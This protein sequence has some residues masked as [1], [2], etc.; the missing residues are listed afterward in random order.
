LEK[1]LLG[2][3]VKSHGYRVVAKGLNAAGTAEVMRE[4]WDKYRHCVAV[5]LDASRF[6]QHVGQDAL[7]F[8]HSCYTSIFPASHELPE[9]LRM[10]LS[11]RGQGFAEGKK[12]KYR[13]EGCRMSGDINT[14]MGNC[15]I[16]SSIVLGYLRTRGIDARLTNNG[17]DCVL[18]LEKHDL[19]QLDGIDEWFTEFGFKL[20]QEA[21]VDVFEKIEFCQTQPVHCSDGWRMVRNPYTASSKDAVSLL[22]WAGE[23]EFD[24]WRGAISTCG[25]S[26]TTGVP[27]WEKYYSRLG[28]EL[29]AGSFERISDSGLGYM[30][31]GM[32]SN[33][34]ITPETRYSFWLAFGMLPD[35]QVELESM[36]LSIARSEATPMTFGDVRPLHLLLTQ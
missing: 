24:R 7:K 31:H 14:S 25:L 9:L 8:E 5:G 10:Q 27:F 33:A 35:V 26:L 23:L 17:D 29:H 18:F 2:S 3:Y 32:S 16:M 36:S 20:T 11:N 34:K 4:N 6:D 12:V 15:V 19:H 28:G 30:S 21:P 1:N 22:S 13:V